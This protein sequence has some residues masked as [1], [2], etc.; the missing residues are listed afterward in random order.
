[1]GV[2][3]PDLSLAF[4]VEVYAHGL[5]SGGAEV[6]YRLGVRGASASRGVVALVGSYETAQV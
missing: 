5:C 6:V 1:V 3:E 2:A 4:E